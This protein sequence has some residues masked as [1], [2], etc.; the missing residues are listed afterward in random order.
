MMGTSRSLSLECVGVLTMVV[1]GE[2]VL[3]VVGLQV[4]VSKS[5]DMAVLRAA[6]ELFDGG[7]LCGVIV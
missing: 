1:I 5:N 2:Q 6:F 7:V 4:V 3:A